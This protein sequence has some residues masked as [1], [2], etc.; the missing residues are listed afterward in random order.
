MQP[1][2]GSEESWLAISAVEKASS[3]RQSVCIQIA[4]PKLLQSLHRPKL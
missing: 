1:S 2:P 4:L 3:S